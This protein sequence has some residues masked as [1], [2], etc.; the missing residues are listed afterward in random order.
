[1][2]FLILYLSFILLHEGNYIH[3]VFKTGK[4]MGNFRNNQFYLLLSYSTVFILINP[5]GK[6]KEKPPKGLELKPL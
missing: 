6:T 2:V 1:M 5:K 4:W 3:D